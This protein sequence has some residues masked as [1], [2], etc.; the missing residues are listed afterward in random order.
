M[1]QIIKHG[2]FQLLLSAAILV[3]SH[4]ER[5]FSIIV[6]VTKHIAFHGGDHIDRVDGRICYQCD[7]ESHRGNNQRE[8]TDGE[9]E[10][11]IQT[12]KIAVLIQR[13]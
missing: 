13:K 4:E 2:L 3:F 9:C 7:K 12:V 11:G 5:V 6:L 1:V 10:N 8:D